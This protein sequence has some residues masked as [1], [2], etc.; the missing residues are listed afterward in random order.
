MS[1]RSTR[2]W[3]YL[4]AAL[5]VVVSAIGL[6]NAAG[7]DT[8]D[9]ILE[10]LWWAGTGLLVSEAVFVGGLAVMLAALGMRLSP[11]PMRWRRQWRAAA[12][13]ATSTPTFWVGFWINAVGALATGV[14]GTAAVV[15][16][17]PVT[18]WGLAALPLLDVALTLSVRGA[19][20]SWRQATDSS[21]G[22]GARLE[23]P[24]PTARPAVE[25]PARSRAGQSRPDRP[26]ATELRG[27]VRSNRR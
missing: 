25:T 21:G 18:A 3:V 12:R 10:H 6:A 22:W 7:Q 8:V 2:R 26:S 20:L 17:L 24:P 14:I 1:G 16:T 27:G 13:K 19:A 5:L 11:N 9:R 23:F 4:S 15:V